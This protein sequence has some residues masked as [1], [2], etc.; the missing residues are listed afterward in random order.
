MT[1]ANFD[2]IW[3]S[4]VNERELQL[5]LHNNFV[6][7]EKENHEKLNYNEGF[8][9]GSDYQDADEKRIDLL[10]EELQ[11]ALAEIVKNAFDNLNWE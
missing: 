6:I 8:L 3:D 2:D 9:E 10:I 1:D 7:N 5:N 11:Y 4:D